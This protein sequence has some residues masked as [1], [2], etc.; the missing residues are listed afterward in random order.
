ML[1]CTCGQFAGSPPRSIGTRIG[2]GPLFNPTEPQLGWGELFHANA[3]TPAEQHRA[4]RG[5]QHVQQIL[6]PGIARR[7]SSKPQ[8]PSIRPKRGNSYGNAS[9]YPKL[10]FAPDRRL[11]ELDRPLGISYGQRPDAQVAQLVEHATENRSVG[12]S[13]PPLGTMISLSWD[14]F[15]FWV[16]GAKIPAMNF[17]RVARGS[18]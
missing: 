6:P 9:E 2:H 5:R 17:R 13:I 10:R 1:P 18:G 3:V 16:I 4:E 7:G 8:A 15:G 12:G 14:D 11:S